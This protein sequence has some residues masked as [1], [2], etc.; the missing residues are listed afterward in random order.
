MEEKRKGRMAWVTDLSRA[1]RA[2]PRDRQIASAVS[3][4]GSA[5]G[6]EAG[7]EMPT[8]SSQ[9]LTQRK[10]FI[11]GKRYLPDS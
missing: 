4:L 2:E 5:K 8:I 11:S 7:L 6:V 1:A 10:E 3:P 9:D